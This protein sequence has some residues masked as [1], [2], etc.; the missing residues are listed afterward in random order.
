MRKKFIRLLSPQFGSEEHRRY[1]IYQ[2]ILSRHPRTFG[3]VGSDFRRKVSSLLTQILLVY[4]TVLIED[5]RHDA[6]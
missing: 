1:C 4:N 2:S 3:I 5:E 6:A